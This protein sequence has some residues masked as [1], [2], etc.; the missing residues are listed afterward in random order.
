MKIIAKD[1][2]VPAG[3][4]VKLT[5]WPTIVNLFR[6]STKLYQE[7]LEKYVPE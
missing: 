2:R 7:L 4:K 1:F 5:E 6:K 3:K